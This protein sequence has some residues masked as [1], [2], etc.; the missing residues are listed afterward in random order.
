VSIGPAAVSDA[1]PAIA[2]SSPAGMTST[3]PRITGGSG[4]IW[5]SSLRSSKRF[6]KRLCKL[7]ARRIWTSIK[8]TF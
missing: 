5:A 7:S 6:S 4:A 8:T 3:P 1:R 2:A